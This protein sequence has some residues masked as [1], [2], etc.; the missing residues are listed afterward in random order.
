MHDVMKSTDSLCLFVIR[1]FWSE[2]LKR[3]NRTEDIGVDGMM[4]LEW[5]LGNRVGMRAA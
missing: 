5:I 1:Q 2:N 4:I 3:R